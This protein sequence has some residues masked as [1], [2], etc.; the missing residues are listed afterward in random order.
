MNGVLWPVD[1]LG[2]VSSCQNDSSSAFPHFML[3]CMVKFSKI[4]QKKLKK[5]VFLKKKK[6]IINHL[7]ASY[8][9]HVIIFWEQSPRIL[10]RN[11]LIKKIFFPKKETKV[12]KSFRCAS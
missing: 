7:D 11:L 4:T 9:C 10:L 5:I 6:K 3:V 8:L 2:H 1:N 12:Y